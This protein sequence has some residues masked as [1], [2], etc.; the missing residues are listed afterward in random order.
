MDRMTKIM[1]MATALAISRLGVVSAAP[2][3][4]LAHIAQIESSNRTWI[5]NKKE[6]AY[7]AFQ[8]RKAV[9]SDYNKKHQTHYRLEDMLDI[10]IASE[11]AYWHL[12][13]RIPQLLR[14]I[15]RPVTKEMI[16]RV[17]NSGIGTVAEDRLPRITADY[18]RKYHELEGRK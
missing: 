13:S 8:I 18:I 7:G 15:K 6:G 17:W 3:I 14:Y 5:I 11:V 4:N 2:Q 12:H 16:L 9:L 1:M 10:H